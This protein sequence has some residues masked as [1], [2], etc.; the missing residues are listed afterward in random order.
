[1]EITLEELQIKEFKKHLYKYYKTLFPKQE[2]KPYMVIKN[3]VKKKNM[4]I[5]AIKDKDE[6]QGF[7]IITFTKDKQIIYLEYLAI[8]PKYQSK[9]LGRKKPK[10]I[11]PKIQ[12]KTRHIPRNRKSRRSRN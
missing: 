5:L 10:T 2:R 7:M 6:Y 9:G 12:R 4:Q 11:S 1:M 8:L 3:N